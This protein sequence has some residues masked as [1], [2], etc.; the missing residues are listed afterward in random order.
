MSFLITQMKQE[1]SIEL[2]RTFKLY[3]RITFDE[4]KQVKHCLYTQPNWDPKIVVGTK[5]NFK[6][7]VQTWKHFWARFL[8]EIWNLFDKTVDFSNL[9]QCVMRK[10]H[11]CK[12]ARVFL[13]NEKPILTEVS[14]SKRFASKRS[15]FWANLVLEKLT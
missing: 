9:I 4:L 5:T 12:S 13:R 6:I 14:W 10:Y 8:L 15:K 3:G 2:S 7:L 1:S 11:I